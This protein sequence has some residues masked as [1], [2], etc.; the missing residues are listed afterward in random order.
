MNLEGREMDKQAGGDAMKARSQPVTELPPTLAEAKMNQ[1]G[2]PPKTGNTDVT[3][4][5]PTLAEIGIE[6]MQSHRWQGGFLG[7]LTP[8]AKPSERWLWRQWQNWR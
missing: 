4:L 1:G 8:P 7:R 5:P 2:R 3:G 6:R